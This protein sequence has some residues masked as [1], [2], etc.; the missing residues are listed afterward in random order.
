MTT[1]SSMCSLA[2]SG[3]AKV[4]YEPAVV[5]SRCVAHFDAPTGGPVDE[6]VNPQ[7]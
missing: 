4:N 6:M 5:G 7:G 3:P 1:S 2:P